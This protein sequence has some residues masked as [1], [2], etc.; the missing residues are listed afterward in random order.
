MTWA[1]SKITKGVGAT[2][3]TLF[4]DHSA[5]QGKAC[6]VLVGS[7][8]VPW[9]TA[10]TAP[11]PCMLFSAWLSGMIRAPSLHGLGEEVSPFCFYL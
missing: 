2:N 6:G 1:R 9:C 5:G 7:E 4:V 10:T 11:G 8:E 3:G